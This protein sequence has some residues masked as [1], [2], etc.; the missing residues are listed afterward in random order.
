MNQ[1]T[2]ASRMIPDGPAPGEAASKAADGIEIDFGGIGA[3]LLRNWRVV[4]FIVALALIAGAIITIRSPKLYRASATVQIEQQSSKVLSSDEEQPTVAQDSER[5][6]QTQLSLLNSRTLAALVADQLNLAQAAPTRAGEAPMTPGQRR[7]AAIAQLQQGLNVTLPRDSR[8][9]QITFTGPNPVVVAAVANAY[10]ENFIRYNLERRFGESSY[11]RSFLQRE[12]DAAKRRLET[13][14]SA[15]VNYARANR[16]VDAGQSSGSG[17]QGVRLLTNNS[18]LDVNGALARAQVARIEAERRWQQAANAP[19]IALPEVMANPAIQQL[20]QQRAQLIAGYDRD[21]QSFQADFPAMKETQAQVATLDRQ[22]QRLGDAVR[23]SLRNN[24]LIAQQQENALTAKLES[25]K[26]ETL[27]EQGRSIQYNILRREVDTNRLMYDGLLQ[28]FKE[29]SAAAGITANN[30]SIVD[31]ADVPD[32]PFSPRVRLNLLSALAAGLALA[33]LYVL[34]RTRMDDTLRTPEDVLA[35]TS[36]RVVGA[37]PTKA[38]A[39][40]ATEMMEGSVMSESFWSLRTAVDHLLRDASAKSIL[41]TSARG[42]EGKSTS[43]FGVAESFAQGGRRVVLVDADLRKPTVHRM[44]ALGN[45]RGLASV[46]V[47]ASPLESSLQLAGNR[48]LRVLTSGPL[49]RN[50]AQLLAEPSLATT[51]GSLR[52]RF[53]LTVVDGSP[54]LGLA[55]ALLLASNVG[56]VLFVIEANKTRST[57]VKAALKRLS[58]NGVTVVG[59]ILNRYDQNVEDYNY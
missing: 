37:L 10:A 8:V 23:V 42:G 52:D 58:A 31:R 36:L 56:V 22:I 9:A 55:D 28:R 13:S 19:A 38:A 6:L 5:F 11:A 26:S 35:M 53:D 1:H 57:Q 39:T 50:P 25:L 29:V 24:F 41:L 14:E 4:A 2:V 43:A 33:L 12:L 59:A 18:M 44:L 7:E 3:I 34:I 21:R 46:M 45:D 51:I 48:N 49:T 40:S 27:N 32:R 16:L 17:D 54:V 20:L 47:G 15:V 30:I